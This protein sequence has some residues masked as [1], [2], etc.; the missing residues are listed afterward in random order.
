VNPAMKH[1]ML[2]HAFDTLGTVR[3]ELKTDA[4]NL[5][6]RNAILK[7]GA[8]FEGLLRAHMIMPDG[9]LRDTAVYSITRGEWASVD[10]GLRA[11][12]EA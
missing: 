3:V 5:H 7:L 2:L 9:V 4:R 1:L 10:A 8:V 6:S 11:R 12:F